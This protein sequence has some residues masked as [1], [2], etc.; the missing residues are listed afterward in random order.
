MDSFPCNGRE[1]LNERFYRSAAP[2]GS[3]ERFN[4]HPGTG[5]T[6]LTAQDFWIDV[7][8]AWQVGHALIVHHCRAACSAKSTH[9]LAFGC[10]NHAAAG[11]I[12]WGM[13]RAPRPNRPK[14]HPSTLPATKARKAPTRRV[15]ADRSKQAPNNSYDPVDFYEDVLF[16]CVDCQKQETW[17]AEDQK[18]WYEVAK[19]PIYSQAIRCRACRQAKRA[20]HRGTP[21][22]PR[23]QGSTKPPDAE[24]P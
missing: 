6:G 17:T 13:S 7:D 20:A 8:G 22:K 1:V 12:L 11:D 16:R 19:G 5:E 3:P 21:R 23:S 10:V 4:G 14:R 15:P 9:R 18:W 2:Q 24:T